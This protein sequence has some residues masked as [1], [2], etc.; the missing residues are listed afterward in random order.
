MQLSY[1][2]KKNTILESERLILR[3]IRMSDAEDM[4]DYSRRPETSKYLLWSPHES[5]SVTAETLKFILN[6]YETDRFHDFAVILKTNGKMIGTAGFTSVDEKN[7]C[8]EIGYVLNP[9]YHGQ[10]I[11]TEAVALLL[12]FAFCEVGFNRI[13]AKFLSENLPS[14]R[15]MEKCDMTFEGTLR[16]KM[17]IK[18][19]FRNI[20]ICSILSSEYFAVPRENLY[21]KSKKT[22]LIERFFGKRYKN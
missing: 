19:A 14:R 18:G 17:F 12:N 21:K 6:E 2:F 22:T 11:A 5:I 1:Y 13:E 9:D 10:G 20:G 3:K 7:A 16:S 4:Y 15:V 8:A